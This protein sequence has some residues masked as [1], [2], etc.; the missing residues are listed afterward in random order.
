MY[1]PQYY[2]QL[3]QGGKQHRQMDQKEHH[4]QLSLKIVNTTI[5]CVAI[6]E[7]CH[8]YALVLFTAPHMEMS[9]HQDPNPS[10]SYKELG[11]SK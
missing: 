10:T 7:D 5:N 4:N 11:A 8:H 9:T 1:I 6:T 3:C 2:P